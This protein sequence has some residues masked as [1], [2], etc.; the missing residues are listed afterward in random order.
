M[1]PNP[2]SASCYSGT[3]GVNFGFWKLHLLNH[4]MRWSSKR[5][6][7]QYSWII[8]K[9]MHVKGIGEWLWRGKKI[10]GRKNNIHLA[11]RM[12]PPQGS[13]TFQMPSP[14]IRTPHQDPH[15]PSLVEHLLP[16]SRVLQT[17]YFM[18]GNVPSPHFCCFS[19]LI[20]RR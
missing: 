3:L 1:S 20:A 2:G 4:K 7:S 13:L 6:I 11:S 10:R 18:P 14:D 5:S 17:P 8:Q 16:E 9:W 12:P 15:G 19:L